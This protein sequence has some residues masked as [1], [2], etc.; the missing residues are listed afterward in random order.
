MDALGELGIRVD[1][2]TRPVEVEVAIPFE[3]NTRDASYDADADLGEF[4]LPYEAVRKADSPDD[5]LMAFLQSTYEAAA[6]AGHWDRA[7]LDFAF[8]PSGQ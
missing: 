4:V 3:S 8:D 6:E 2:F 1:I 5:A 7:A